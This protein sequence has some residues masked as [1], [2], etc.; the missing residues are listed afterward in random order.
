MFNLG[1]PVLN[2]SDYHLPSEKL[3][4]FS[5][6]GESGENLRWFSGEF[7]GVGLKENME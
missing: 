6:F 5:D 3:P 7:S 2:I 4:S 1:V